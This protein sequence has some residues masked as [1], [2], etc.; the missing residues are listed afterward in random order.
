MVKPKGDAGKSNPSIP[1]PPFK[2]K[3]TAIKRNRPKSGPPIAR[4]Y[5]KEES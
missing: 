3:F 4:G 1:S 2:K 5:A